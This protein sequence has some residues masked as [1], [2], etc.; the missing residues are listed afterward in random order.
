MKRLNHPNVIAAKEVPSELNVTDG[1]LPLLAMEFCS[2]GDLRRVMA[3]KNHS[4]LS[5]YFKL[6]IRYLTIKLSLQSFL[7]ICDGNEHFK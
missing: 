5:V 3:L 4:I 7:L 2:G 1:E 6:S